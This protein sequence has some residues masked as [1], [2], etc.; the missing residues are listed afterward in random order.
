M[1]NTYLSVTLI[2]F[3]LLTLVFS[4]L[5]KV[6]PGYNFMVLEIGNLV[7]AALSVV[8]Y[9]MVTKNMERTQSFV[10]GV[11]GSSFLRLM[12]CMV[13]ML[14]YIV[15]NRTH[16]HKPTVF[17]LFGIYAIYTTA[18]TLLL[19]KIAKQKS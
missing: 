3:A 14:V 13:S 1:K 19:T 18:E 4:L 15:M 16:I 11:S 8:T 10:R 6:A 9:F 17:V 5:M 12:V 2:L 7:M